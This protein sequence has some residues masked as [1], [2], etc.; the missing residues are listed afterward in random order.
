MHLARSL[1][2]VL[3]LQAKYNNNNKDN[4]YVMSSQLFMC[5]S[6]VCCEYRHIIYFIRTRHLNEAVSD[7]NSNE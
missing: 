3:Q 6:D 7:I 4:K 2:L 1:L 5:S